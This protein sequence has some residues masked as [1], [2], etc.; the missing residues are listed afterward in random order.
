MLQCDEFQTKMNH[1]LE[2]FPDCCNLEISHCLNLMAGDM[3]E[4]AQLI[5]HRQEMGQSLQPVKKVGKTVRIC[6]P[7][8]SESR[9][10]INTVFSP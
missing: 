4:T 9:I 5:I 8:S 6:I 10:V 3:E 7:D 1:L 2:M